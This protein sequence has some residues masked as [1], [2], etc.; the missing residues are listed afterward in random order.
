MKRSVSSGSTS[1]SPHS[2]LCW[3][4]CLSYSSGTRE[5]KAEVHE[6]VESLVFHEKSDETS[7]LRAEKSSQHITQI[8]SRQPKSHQFKS[9]P[10]LEKLRA[11]LSKLNSSHKY[12][13]NFLKKCLSQR[14]NYIHIHVCICIYIT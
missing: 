1:A 6:E 5:T 9:C 14:Q 10:R 12:V 13:R 8:I 7:S 4:Y 3:G 2:Q 11:L